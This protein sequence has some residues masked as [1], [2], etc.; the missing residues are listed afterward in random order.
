MWMQ[1]KALPPLFV[2]MWLASCASRTVTPTPIA[3][4]GDER[5]TCAQLIEQIT[6]NRKEFAQAQAE[7]TEVGRANV[8]KVATG[9]L[10]VPIGV[11]LALSADLSSEAQV[12]GRSL[13]DRN[14]RLVALANSKGC[15][16]P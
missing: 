2:V 11:L 3:Q 5:L 6:A 14:E 9:A 12:R 7:D 4:A 16:E 10:L 15:T 13:L 8:A 1:S